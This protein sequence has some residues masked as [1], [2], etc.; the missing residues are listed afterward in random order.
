MFESLFSL[1]L[2][3]WQTGQVFFASDW[4]EWLFAAAIA[5]VGVAIAISLYRQRHELSFSKLTWLWIMQSAVATVLLVMLWQPS[6]R[7][8]NIVSSD[9]TVVMLLDNS[10]SMVNAEGDE[11]RLQNVVAKLELDTLEKISSSFETRLYAVSE[12]IEPLATLQDIPEAGSRSYLGESIKQSLENAVREP[13]AAVVLISD[14]SDNGMQSLQPDWWNDIRQYGVPV[15]TVG[16]GRTRMTEDLELLDVRLAAN[17]L[18]GSVETALLTIRHGQGGLASLKVYDG[19]RLIA[20]NEISLLETSD[21]TVYALELPNLE[22]GVHKLRFALEYWAGEVNLNNNQQIRLL[23]V[24]ERPRRVLYVEGE[25]RW[26]FKFIRRALRDDP[27]I[28]LVSLLRTSPNKFYRQ[29]IESREEL[30]NGF[31]SDR[32]TLFSYDAIIIG[33][34]DAAQLNQKQHDNLRDFVSERGG[35]LLMLAGKDGL[36]GGGWHRSN[37]AD[38]LP[39]HLPDVPEGAFSRIQR[40]AFLSQF[41]EVSPITRLSADVDENVRLWS[42]MPLLANYQSAGSLKPGAQALLEAEDAGAKS[43]LLVWQRYGLGHS[44]L[45]ATAGTWRWQMQLPS[46]DLRHETFW[47][48]LLWSMVET[49]PDKMTVSTPSTVR[50]D[51]DRSHVEIDL[52]NERFEPFIGAEV[53]LFVDGPSGSRDVLTARPDPQSPGIYHADIQTPS[54]GIYRVSATANNQQE[55]ERSTTTW[56]MQNGDTAEYF[57]QHQN[58][59]WLERVAEE[60]G[61]RYLAIDELNQLPAVLRDN[62]A[63]LVRE[64][65]FSLWNMP[66]FFLLIALLKTGEWLLRLRWRRI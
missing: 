33:S 63:G 4:P 14:G 62:N 35:S 44:Y 8:E 2:Q 11:T 30:E 42:E 18:P 41:G 29:G 31:P 59:R 13:L 9:N 54:S 40:K 39:V 52:K 27:T 55:G 50:S 6:I 10:A 26:E 58:K 3:T 22:S 1:P 46:E 38:A 56:V 25:P 32:K 51:R 12:G 23:Q 60:T 36:S 57:S 66:I 24:A 34:F 37:V 5:T 53:T 61:G 28:R 43:P 21:E 64:Q 19:E 65:I 20:L 48:Q 49:V 17:S 16:V 15:H 47:R 7:S 45:L